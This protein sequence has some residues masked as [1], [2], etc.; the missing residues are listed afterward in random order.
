MV[1]KATI[2]NFLY[3]LHP[4]TWNHLIKSSSTKTVA[5]AYLFYG[6]PGSGKEAIAI[7]FAQ[8]LNCDNKN[9]FPC[10][11]CSSCS[12]FKLLHHEKMKIIIP[13]PVPQKSLAKSENIEASSDDYSDQLIQKSKDI[14]FKMNISKSNRILIQSIK[15]LKKTFNLSQD[16][17]GRNMVLI[18]DAH[19]L[20]AGQGES[21]NAL[22][23][24][25]EEPPANTS[26]ILVSDYRSLMLETLA[27][28]CQQLI[29]KPLSDSFISEY[30]NRF[31]ITKNDSN[32]IT[33]L[34]NGNINI[35][36][37]LIEYSALKAV[38]EIEKL[39]ESILSADSRMWRKFIQ[40]FSRVGQNN[41]EDFKFKFNLL[42][43]WF[44]NAQKIKVGD[45]NDQNSF[46]FFD[47]INVFN[48]KYP[49]A[50][51]LSIVMCFED[52]IDS[53]GKNLHMPLILMGLLINIQENIK[54]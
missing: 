24:I 11:N 23:K 15:A 27:S 12:R 34:S 16:S 54:N 8:L 45:F 21:G 6:S 37:K 5:N 32:I 46:V 10:Y 35:A 26:F 40:D 41:T 4:S 44:Y 47:K 2:E 25:L 33:S 48:I 9:G 17:K 1:E 29:F 36:K 38:D 30:L 53:L 28:R 31:K 19:L 42:I 39:I 51:L 3:S 20:S 49:N 7:K 14:F 50:N 43:L 13:L 18:F 22:L 52:A